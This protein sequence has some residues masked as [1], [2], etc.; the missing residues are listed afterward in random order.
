MI[1]I[2]PSHMFCTLK[3]I[4][5]FKAFWK[6]NFWCGSTR[7]ENLIRGNQRFSCW[8]KKSTVFYI[9]GKTLWKGECERRFWD[10]NLNISA[11]SKVMSMVESALKS[12]DSILFDERTFRIIITHRK[13]SSPNLAHI[14]DFETWERIT[15]IKA[16][17]KIMRV[18]YG[19]LNL[20]EI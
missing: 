1:S 20:E 11:T 9:Q 2:G 6:T 10:S 16:G 18:N 13:N 3:S 15:K 19:K 8:L 5:A 7:L 14:Q 12:W 4:S 17:N